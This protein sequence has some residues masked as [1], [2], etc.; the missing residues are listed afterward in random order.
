MHLRTTLLVV[1]ATAGIR[2][3]TCIYNG[4]TDPLYVPNGSSY[5]IGVG[6]SRTQVRIPA[7][8]LQ[9][10][11]HLITELSFAQR[12]GWTLHH[13]D[14]LVVRMG[15]TTA[16]P[17]TANF[18]QNVTTPLQTV[19]VVD[20]HDW[21]FGPGPA[22][23]P[24]GLQVP[25]Q[26]L[27]GQGDIL[28]EIRTTGATVT[29]TLWSLGGPAV[30]Q[31]EM[32]LGQMTSGTG[33]VYNAPLLRLCV[34]HPEVSL[35]GHN[36]PG[37]GGTAPLLGITGVPTPGAQPTFWLSNAPP[38]GIAIAAYGFDNE[39]P[40]P[41]NLTPFG[42]TGC[43]QYFPLVLLEPVLTNGLGIGQHALPLSSSPSVVGNI[44]LGQ[45]FVL[46]PGANALGI[47][48]SNYGRMLIG[49]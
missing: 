29:E 43:V 17:L 34:D 47:T 8:F 38:N 40:F 31:G 2:A 4:W 14:Q 10:V 33:S 11:P 37:T 28:V 44:I 6:N 20:N 15:H 16:G 23:I 36:C 26:F 41:V 32:V 27:P 7:V 9:N 24:V 45:Y 49:Q 3:Q 48:A 22:W 12:G 5:V 13:F 35:H 18:A 39:P 30:V 19:L 25:F 46:D 21:L 1:L 42:A